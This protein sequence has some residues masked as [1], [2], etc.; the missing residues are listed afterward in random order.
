VLVAVTGLLLAVYLGITIWAF[1]SPATD[2]QRG[3]AQGFITMV[4]VFL[5]GLGGLLWY[6]VQSHRSKLVW[7]VFGICA[8]PSL[9]LVGR[10][11]YLLVRWLQ[12]R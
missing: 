4:L 7:L 6:G 5:L 3:M 11:V 12:R 8:L 10:V 2:P 1:M 9:S